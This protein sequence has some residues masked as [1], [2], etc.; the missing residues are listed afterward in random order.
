[1]RREIILLASVF[2]IVC[3][4]FEPVRHGPTFVLYDDFAYVPENHGPF[5]A[6]APR[7]SAGHSRRS[8][9]TTGSRSPGYP[10]AGYRAFRCRPG[11]P[12]S[13]ECRIALRKRNAPLRPAALYHGLFVQSAFV[14]HCS[15]STRCTSS[16]SLDRRAEGCPLHLLLALGNALLGALCAKREPHSL[17]RSLRAARSR[18]YDQPMLVTFPFTLLLLDVWPLGRTRLAKAAA[19]ARPWAVPAR[20]LLVEKLP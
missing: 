15:P 18:A 14:A 12:S 13:G 17:C 19:A 11:S 4:V 8:Q 7:A 6:S 1:M 9:A 10:T 16:R 5:G 3:V 20:R 2:F